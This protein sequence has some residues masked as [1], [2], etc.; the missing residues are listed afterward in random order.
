MQSSGASII[1]LT[2]EDVPDTI[3]DFFVSR[4]HT[5]Y[6]VKHSIFESE[7]DDV[8]AKLAQQISLEN[9]ASVVL[10]TW[11]HVHFANL[12]AR[13]PPNNNLRFRALGRLSMTC[14]RP[15]AM[16]RLTETIED[17]ER[18]YA[19]CQSRDDKRLIMTL[20]EISLNIER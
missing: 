9:N 12:I 14:R 3:A 15:A 7:P 1:F 4:G 20:T 5:V 19:L 6:T 11:N 2:D 16:K 8:I 17:I 10:V 18:E 13:R